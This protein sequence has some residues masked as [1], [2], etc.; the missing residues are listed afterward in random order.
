[1][2]STSSIPSESYSISDSASDSKSNPNLQSNIINGE[3]SCNN[4]NLKFFGRWDKRID[5]VYVGY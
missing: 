4:P 1:M 3:V 5:N 2:N